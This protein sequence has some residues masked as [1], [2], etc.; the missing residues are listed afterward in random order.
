MVV[1]T[2]IVALKKLND[3]ILIIPKMRAVIPMVLYPS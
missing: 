1:S 2:G 3:A